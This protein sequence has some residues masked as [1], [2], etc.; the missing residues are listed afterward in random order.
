MTISMLDI[1]HSEGLTQSVYNSIDVEYEG[2]E[3]GVE[4]Y[5]HLNGKYCQW[6]INNTKRI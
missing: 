4:Y 1:K 6:F 3:L 5:K 2:I